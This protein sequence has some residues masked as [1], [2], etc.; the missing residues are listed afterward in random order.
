M[1]SIEINQSE[2]RRVFACIHVHYGGP[3]VH[4]MNSLSG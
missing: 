4:N 2:Y 3:T 1:L